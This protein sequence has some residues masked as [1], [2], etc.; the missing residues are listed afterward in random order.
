MLHILIIE[1]DQ[2]I[3]NLIRTT[4][5]AEGYCCQCAGDGEEGIKVLNSR[6]WD[7]VLL[8]LM[9]PYISGYEILDYMRPG[10]TPVIILSAMGNVDDRIRGLKMGA[11]DYLVKPFQ[12]GELVARVESVL[13]RAGLVQTHLSLA[14]VELDLRSLKVTK[15]GKVIEMTPKEF[16]MLVELIRHKNVALT[17]EYLYES[18]WQEEYTGETRTLDSHIQRIRK[19]L[20]WN[21]RIVT[22]FRVGYRLED[23]R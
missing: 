4:L 15:A 5:S 20:D 3:A 23:V 22:V 21:D 8:D 19:K 14:D 9:L 13:R 12:I 1:D 18:V 2:A 10:D 16:A 17:R 6:K 11:D 7:L